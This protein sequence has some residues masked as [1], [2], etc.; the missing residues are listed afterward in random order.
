[1][2]NLDRVKIDKF[3]NRI[4]E[5]M[6]KNELERIKGC[7][8]CGTCTGGCPAGR[9]TAMRTRVVVRK[10][11]LGIETVLSDPDIWMCST[12]YTCLERCPRNIPITNVIIMLR[13]LATQADLMLDN[14]R[15][16]T[17]MFIKTG[18]GVPI[19]EG[20]AGK[21]W[22]DLRVSYDLPPLPPTVHSF[23]ES[24]KNLH[25]LVKLIGFDKL[26]GYESEEE[27]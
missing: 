22:R 17:H 19:P 27:E 11:L 14:H 7:Y 20:D 15:K 3:S 5:E 6:V 23:P 16:L 1:M 13:N 25:K 2:E 10:A 8:Q 21:K 24:L 18:H 26:V 9:S 12:C 4:T